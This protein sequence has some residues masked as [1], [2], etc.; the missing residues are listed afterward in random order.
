MTA[1]LAGSS[2]RS[3]STRE[4]TPTIFGQ[5]LGDQKHVYQAL[6]YFRRTITPASTYA[7]T[8]DDVKRRLKLNMNGTF[9]DLDLQAHISSAQAWFEDET[10]SIVM[11]TTVDIGFDSF[12]GHSGLLPLW[13][14]PVQAVTSITYLDL[15]GDATVMDT[16]DYRV[17]L[18]DRSGAVFPK[19][20]WPSTESTEP[21]HYERV[22]LRLEC[23]Y[24]DQD[25][26]PA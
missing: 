11:P 21:Y 24:L 8:L 20:E 17:Q 7:L 18:W 19:T 1:A 3:Q 6:H 13:M 4:F 22:T 10:N 14:V 15:A 25:S 9:E 23:G 2:F 5:Y 12:P 26:V 16:D